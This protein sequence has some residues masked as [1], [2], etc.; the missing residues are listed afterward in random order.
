MPQQP[1]NPG[2]GYLPDWRQ[3]IPDESIAQGNPGNEFSDWERGV[4]FLARPTTH[5]SYAKRWA[6]TLTEQERARARELIFT[7]IEAASLGFLPLRSIDKLVRGKGNVEDVVFVGLMFV[8]LLGLIRYTRIARIV[9][10]IRSL[11]LLKIFQ[12]TLPFRAR[13]L[14][15][16]ILAADVMLDAKSYL[17]AVAWFGKRWP[18]AVRILARAA[19]RVRRMSDNGKRMY[20]LLLLIIDRQ[21]TLATRSV[22]TRAAG[23]L[24]RYVELFEKYGIKY[25]IDPLLGMRRV[26]FIFM[27]FL[28]LEIGLED[29]EEMS[30]SLE[31][32]EKEAPVMGEKFPAP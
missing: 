4:G 18:F 27:R 23:S 1:Y 9:P 20:A 13:G 31:A 7:L 25:E 26:A 2:W 30:K 15:R 3:P 24:R 29:L 10:E 21:L 11:Y 8:P 22:D 32:I 28:D 12:I 5:G 19:P 14:R 6:N 16:F 17:K